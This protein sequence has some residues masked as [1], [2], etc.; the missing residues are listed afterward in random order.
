MQ[1]ADDQFQ[2]LAQAVA[3]VE[4][5]PVLDH[6]R[7]E[8]RVRTNGGLTVY[9]WGRP[10]ERRHVQVRD[11]SRGGM[12]VLHT[13]RAGLDDLFV[14][15][16]AQ[17]EGRDIIAMLCTVAYWEPLK[18][19]LYAIGMQFQRPLAVAETDA[20]R[21]IIP[22]AAPGIIARIGMMFQPW[23]VAS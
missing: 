14:A 9:P 15:E 10:D 16:L 8:P 6:D 1:L 20:Q 17:G 21:N 22:A 18:E 23:R 12:G 5:Q 11:L 4:T 7:R 2:A 13:C 3:V 19:D